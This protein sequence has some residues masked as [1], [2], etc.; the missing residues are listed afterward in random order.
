MIPT[1]TESKIL[2]GRSTK[3]IRWD[4]FDPFWFDFDLKGNETKGSEPHCE[5]LYDDKDIATKTY[6]DE[7]NSKQN[8]AVNNKAIKD[9]I[10][11]TMEVNQWLEILTRMARK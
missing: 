5:S 4:F 3:N 8:L 6:V 9:E 11:I 7:Q 10:L 1:S 2:K